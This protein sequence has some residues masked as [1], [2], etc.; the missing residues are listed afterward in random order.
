VTAFE[1]KIE[2]PIPCEQVIDTAAK[3]KV[4]ADQSI[5]NRIVSRL[6]GEKLLVLSEVSN[7]KKTRCKHCIAPRIVLSGKS[8]IDR[9][10]T[11]P[12]HGSCTACR[13][14]DDIELDRLSRG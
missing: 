7:L 12:P 3:I 13:I 5:I 11:R 1:V 10:P 8:Y 14:N 6:G 4:E 9:F 2:T